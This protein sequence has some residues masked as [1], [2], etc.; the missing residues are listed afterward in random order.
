M[1]KKLLAVAVAGLLTAPAAALA[2]SSVTI[3]GVFKISGENVR[4]GSRVA[5]GLN[6]SMTRLAD[7]SSRIIFN[8]TEDLGGGLAAI[9]QLDVRFKYDDGGTTA[10]ANVGGAIGAGNT[11][12]GL[13]S[14]S[15]GQLTFGRNDLHY[16]NTESRL[17]SKAASLRHDTISLISYIQGTAI[18]N[19]SRSQN[20][21]RYLSPNWGGFTVIAAYST[22]A[23]GNDNDLAS[24]GR[25]GRA[26][27]LNPNFQGRNFQVGYSYWSAKA[28]AT[29]TTTAA[30]PA[31][32]AL[33]QTTGATVATPAVAAVT[34][35]AA[36]DQRGD[37]LYGS[38]SWGGFRAGLAWDKSRLRNGITG[39]DT[40]RRTAWA[41]PLEFVTGNHN[42][43]FHY[44]KARD[45]KVTAAQDGAKM[46]A[47]AYVYDMSK[48][49][50][51]GVSYSKITNDAG[52]TY[53]HFTTTSLGDA[54]AAIAAGEDPRIFAATIRHAF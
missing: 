37:R 10:A 36:V 41:I 49:T 21:T 29:T 38:M 24:A 17:T 6:N 52:S 12:V 32:F 33:N 23:T 13:R 40:N 50:S 42:F 3:S 39:V 1:Q 51:V 26:W 25:K 20:V 43:L 35:T 27:N 18:A 7:D 48:R 16:F 11:F 34:T 4:I 9:G 15:W 44:T 46:F 54:S 14:K 30:V 53:N 31:G 2:Q 22:M 8:V 45:D 47:M 28:D 5:A 19:A